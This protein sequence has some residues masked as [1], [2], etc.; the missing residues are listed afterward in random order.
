MKR[1]DFFLSLFF[2]VCFVWEMKIEAD[3][4]VF[5]D[6]KLQLVG[7]SKAALCFLTTKCFLGGA[8]S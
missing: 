1:I 6:R 3:P 2:F 4:T 5:A 8:Y 7:L